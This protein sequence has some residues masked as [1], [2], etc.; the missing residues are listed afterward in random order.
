MNSANF[1]VLTDS[2]GAPM[3]LY[4]DGALPGRLV[5]EPGGASWPLP[6]DIRVR[7]EEYGLSFKPE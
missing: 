6:E 5:A 1:I 7:L 4:W 3:R 2:D